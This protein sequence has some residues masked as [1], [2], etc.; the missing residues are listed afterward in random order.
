[1]SGQSTTPIIFLAFA[2][3]RQQGG[4]YLRNLGLEADR[5]RTCLGRANAICEVVERHSVTPEQI[6]QVFQQYKG[7][8]AIFHYAGH[9]DD[10]ILLLEN[11]RGEH[12]LADA[13]GLA[14]LL[15]QQQGLQLV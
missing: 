14:E 3:D 12:V 2:N 8:V 13:R 1:M 15:R 4:A 11:S 7:R 6:L 9:A 10:Y 5:L